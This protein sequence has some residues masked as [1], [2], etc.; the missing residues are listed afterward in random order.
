MTTSTRSVALTSTAGLLLALALP[1]VQAEAGG[2]LSETSELSAVGSASLVAGSVASVVGTGELVVVSIEWL[3]DG[4]RC[5]FRG[6]VEVGRVVLIIPVK[7]VGATS[8]AVGQTVLITAKGT[9]W[10]ITKAGEVIAFIPNEAGEALLF[11]EPVR[12]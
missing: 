2:K 11:S 1:A 12:R 6:S 8:L 4:A 3:A 9:G 7:I 10:L 5:V